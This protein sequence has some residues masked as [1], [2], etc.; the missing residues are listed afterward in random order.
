MKAAAALL[1]AIVLPAFA[2]PRF[3]EVKAAHRPSDIEFVDR[4]GQPLQ[5]LR[6][7]TTVRRFAWM[8]LAEMSPALRDAVVLSEDRRFWA[9]GG[10]D[11]RALA[12]AA[13]ANA[14]N[15][16]TRGASTL[17]MQLAGLLDDELARP[18]GGRGLAAKLGQAAAAKALERDWTKAQILEAY[19]N[20]VPLRADLV[21][22]P[23]A[24]WTL[25]G[26]RPG[27]LDAAES[28]LLAVLVRAPN[29]G[30]PAVTR[31][32]CE[33]LRQQQRG[34][35]GLETTVEQALA[36]RPRAAPGE[37]LAPHFAKAWFAAGGGTRLP[38]DGGVQRVAL[39]ALRQQLAELRGRN[40]DD[41]AVLVLD[42]ASG[43]VRAWVGSGGIGADEVDAV[44]ARR[45]PGST[46]KPF[47]YAL[48]FERRLLTPA[49]RLDD[50]PLELAAGNGL[51]APQN[52]DHAFKGE[53][54]AR[55]A[56]GSSL[57]VPAVRVAA[58][59]G[60]DELFERLQSAGLD[61]KESA[62]YH[63]PALALG[64]AE[65]TLL[66]LTNAYRMLANGG[67][68]SAAR[69]TP[70]APAAP[71]RVFDPA[72]A[73]LVAD[74]LADAAARATTFGFD[75]PLVT[76]GWAAVK[77][78]TSKDLRDNW[79]VGYTSR[80]TVG[81]WVGNADGEPMHA[82]S[83]VSGAAPVW[84]QVVAALH[85]AEVS[86]PPRPPLGI[87][88]VA[89]RP[90]IAGT[91]PARVA[92][93]AGRFG[94]DSPRDGSIIVI[95]PEIPPA[96]QRLVFEGAAG[97]WRVDGVVV[98]AG[99]R[100]DWRPRPGRHRLEREGGGITE[101]V[102]FEVRIAPLEAQD[103]GAKMRST[104]ASITMPHRL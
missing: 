33:L 89:R 79:C 28:A 11:W 25:F 93:R 14:W 27:G 55:I 95:D 87:V 92:G 10:V 32:T 6:V 47:I 13:W 67:R 82:V 77:T 72:A 63:G 54:S 64:S 85:A 99:E 5:V 58:M 29:A 83:G 34:C 62:G 30:V 101:R 16:R 36:R 102:D 41:G 49:S 37:M 76:R 78:G 91:E 9:H 8:P 88:Q 46:L 60:P 39:Q 81:V 71:R 61:L 90:F 100:V 70:Q 15:Q 44:L 98:G 86:R 94:I 1:V 96:Q 68:W 26:K 18:G 48:A 24:A 22:V 40:V 43:E 51:Y 97:R 45:Q 104:A 69:N 21:G 56:L 17:T 75:S 12:G 20:R 73:Y 38:L 42:N 23:A 35:A 66:G 57:N 59:L 65:T 80:Y 52:Y 50:S 103:A 53:V 2:L 19:L 3:D 74:I 84:R 4:D 7:D 31:R